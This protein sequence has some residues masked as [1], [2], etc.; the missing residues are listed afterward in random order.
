MRNKAVGWAMPSVAPKQF[1]TEMH[2]AGGHESSAFQEAPTGNSGAQLPMKTD[3]Y[4]AI[5]DHR[6][7]IRD[8]LGHSLLALEPGLRLTYLSSI[9]EF[10]ETW[11]E[12]EGTPS[13]LLLNMSSLGRIELVASHVSHVEG[14][15]PD[16]KVIVLSE[17]ERIED[18]L[19][20]FECGVSG[21][22]PPSIGLEVAM[23][24]L[25]LVAAGGVYVP[26]SVLSA[27]RDLAN[28]Q[29]SAAEVQDP[30]R[31]E[32]TSKQLAV[33]EALCRG[34]S[35]KIIAYDLNMCEST[36]KVH[37][38]KVMKTLGARSRTEAA[39][40]LSNKLNGG[41][42]THVERFS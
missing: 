21:Y 33:I 25:H 3:L 31:N 23:R 27:Q 18:I 36:V 17:T 16:T 11:I 15:A 8:C 32:F 1:A 6:P 37:V 4:V 19:Q 9:D 14:L 12:Q 30:S 2:H 28:R 13:I 29:T 26:A 20:V 40:I 34:K 22:I 10:D 35:N 24:A 42:R 5:V 7:L 39:Y 38:R 41:V